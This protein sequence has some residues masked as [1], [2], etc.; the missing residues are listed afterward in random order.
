[1][2]WGKS[3]LSRVKIVLQEFQQRANKIKKEEDEFKQF[4]KNFLEAKSKLKGMKHRLQTLKGLDPE[5]AAN[6]LL[7]GIPVDQSVQ[8]LIKDPVAIDAAEL[9]VRLPSRLLSI[10]AR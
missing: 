9:F 1:M 2:E 8:T 6:E 5:N 10:F 4:R 7:R 3:H